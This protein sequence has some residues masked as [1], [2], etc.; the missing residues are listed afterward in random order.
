MHATVEALYYLASRREVARRNLLPVPDSRC[1]ALCDDKLLFNRELIRLGHGSCIPAL[2]DRPQPPY[3]LKPRVGV[4]SENCH[5]VRNAEDEARLPDLIASPE[6]FIQ[7]LVFGRSEFAT[8]ML[9]RDGSVVSELTIEYVAEEGVFLKG[10][11]K[12]TTTRLR[13]CAYTSLFHR[14]LEGL[15]FQGLCCFNYKV[16]CGQVQIFEL[17]PRFGYSLGAYF[18]IFLSDLATGFASADSTV[19]A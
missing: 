13:R 17:N 5:I 6:Y 15:G 18:G 8:H 7:A 12:F 14:I 19:A 11:Y 10:D 16:V 4:N 2:Q 9:I 3:I 1:V